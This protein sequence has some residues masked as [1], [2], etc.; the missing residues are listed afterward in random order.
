MYIIIQIYIFFFHL[1]TSQVRPMWGPTNLLDRWA[2]TSAWMEKRVFLSFN[3]FFGFFNLLVFLLVGLTFA[4]AQ[5]ARKSETVKLYISIIWFMLAFFRVCLNRLWLQPT[6]RAGCSCHVGGRGTPYQSWQEPAS[7]A[8]LLTD[9]GMSNGRSPCWKYSC[10]SIMPL[11]YGRL[12]S[13]SVQSIGRNSKM[14]NR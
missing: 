12:G 13:T 10:P 1:P 14:S 2:R 6:V 9:A 8:K 5:R 7:W 11:V 4:R 3:Y